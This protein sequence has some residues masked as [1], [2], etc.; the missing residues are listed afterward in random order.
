MDKLI[1]SRLQIIK[2]LSTSLILCLMFMATLVF[3]SIKALQSDQN[4]AKADVLGAEVQL[5]SLPE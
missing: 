2:I 1:L 4:A 3:F 5:D